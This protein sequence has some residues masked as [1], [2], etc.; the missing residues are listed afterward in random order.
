MLK[1]VVIA[2][3]F[4]LLF[5]SLSSAL[6]NKSTTGRAIECNPRYDCT[7]WS[8]CVDDFTTRV[9]KD[10]AC[11]TEDITERKLCV[12]SSCTPNIQCGAWNS[13]VFT[14][15][16]S[17]IFE[18][19]I[20]FEGY[21]ER[22]CIDY[23]NCTAP[24]T[25]E[26]SCKDTFPV[27]FITAD[28]CGEKFLTLVDPTYSKPV[29]RINLA[30]W[31]YGKQL[32]LSFVQGETSY[33][34]SCANGI[35]DDNEEGIDC[36][37]SCASCKSPHSPLVTYFS[38]ILWILSLPILITLLRTSSGYKIWRLKALLN[39]G[40]R[41]LLRYNIPKANAIHER[42]VSLFSKLS[43][44]EKAA[45]KGL[46]HDYEFELKHLSKRKLL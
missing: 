1:K 34:P 17:D 9:C 46:L 37:P 30:A 2:F 44:E 36:G 41:A 40:E 8:S 4:V 6:T 27:K 20:R 10:I 45:T 11:G 38:T 7:E 31:R 3:V 12:S 24:F 28:H 13:C 25:E 32:E 39:K 23:N 42:A 29:T 14:A 16:T 18:S 43:D 33:C 5:I 26:H 35:Q 19:N 15:K 21:Q 22:P